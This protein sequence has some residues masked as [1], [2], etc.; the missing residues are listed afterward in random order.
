LAAP[1]AYNFWA[2]L[3]LEIFEVFFWL[4]TFALLAALADTWTYDCSFDP[5]YGYYDCYKKRDFTP[6][7]R[8]SS[9]TSLSTY[10]GVMVA[11]AVIAAI[12]L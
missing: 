7:K 9:G 2:V 8:A 1:K 12:E 6:R 4:I 10:Y 5:Y 3:A 11:S